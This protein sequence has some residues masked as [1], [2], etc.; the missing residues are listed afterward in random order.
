M[1]KAHAYAMFLFLLR[2]MFFFLQRERER[3]RRSTHITG[4]HGRGQSRHAEA[5]SQ[6]KVGCVVVP[7]GQEPT[8]SRAYTWREREIGRDREREKR[9]EI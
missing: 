7:K 2:V 5:R 6:G 4:G 9:G 1:H 8:V 3:E